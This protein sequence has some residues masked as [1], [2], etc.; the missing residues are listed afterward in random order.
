[1]DIKLPS[2][3]ASQYHNFS[4]WDKLFILNYY[5]NKERKLPKENKEQI[6]SLDIDE[7]LQKLYSLASDIN[8]FKIE[9]VDN[10]FLEKEYENELK[11]LIERGNKRVIEYTQRNKKVL[12]AKMAEKYTIFLFEEYKHLVEVIKNSSYEKSFKYL[13]I[14]ETLT[15]I[16]RKENNNILMSKRE[17]NKS[18]NEH[19]ILGYDVLDYLSYILK[20]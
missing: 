16:Y 15:K 2:K 8:N 10:K 14:N 17:I 4:F 12:L 3:L 7:Q 6:I 18:I 20:Q 13:M 19:M 9:V 1:M 5:D 11:A